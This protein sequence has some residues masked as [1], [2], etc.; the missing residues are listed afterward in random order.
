MRRAMF[1]G[2]CLLVLSIAVPAAAEDPL[3][4]QKLREFLGALADGRLE[5]AH[6][7]VA[8]STLEYGDPVAKAPADYRAFTRELLPHLD[9]STSDL[10]PKFRNYSLGTPQIAAGECVVRVDFGADKDDV[11][12]VTEGGNWYVKDP[13][14]IIR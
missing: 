13:I 9:R 4:V 5:T 8:P 14:H 3:P 2:S 12:L 11:T 10:Y 7:L 6:H 1:F